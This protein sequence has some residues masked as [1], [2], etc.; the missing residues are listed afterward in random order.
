MEAA[1][2][3]SRHF[4]LDDWGNGYRGFQEVLSFS[5]SVP[6]SDLFATEDN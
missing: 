6:V 4:D 3:R 1:D 2:A 5:S